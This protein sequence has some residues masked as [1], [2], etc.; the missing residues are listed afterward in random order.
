MLLLAEDP[1]VLQGLNVE[2][3]STWGTHELLSL[4]SSLIE[5]K[6][7]SWLMQVFCLTSLLLFSL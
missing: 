3:G 2:E 1:T 6:E 7:S 4:P 5:M